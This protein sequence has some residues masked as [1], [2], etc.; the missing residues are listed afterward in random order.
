MRG[1]G[2]GSGT[3]EPGAMPDGE[4][5]RKAERTTDDLIRE[6]IE[7]RDA[8]YRK[9]EEAR[10]HLERLQLDEDARR[11]QGRVLLQ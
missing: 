6:M 7:E 2:N 9:A 5:A 1:N 10:A 8:A 4:Q 3:Y 11:R